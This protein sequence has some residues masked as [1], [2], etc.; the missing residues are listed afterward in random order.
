MIAVDTNVLAR[1]LV[2][3]PE[4]PEQCAAARAAVAPEELVFVPQVVQAELSWV[5]AT[6]FGFEREQVGTA[7][8]NLRD[9]AAFR[10][11]RREAFAAALEL[12][13]QS[14]ISLADCLILVEARQEEARL[15]TFDRKLGK[16]R[17]AERVG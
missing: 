8:R 2:D 9:N 15:L 5:L 3:D 16:L 7:M 1:I 4:A 10:L 12:F 11:Q 14:A 13:E 17:G 6:G